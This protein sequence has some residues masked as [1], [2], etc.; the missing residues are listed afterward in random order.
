M[1]DISERTLADVIGIPHFVAAMQRGMARFADYRALMPN[2]ARAYTRTLL[3]KRDDYEL[4]AMLWAPASRSPIH[5]HG[6]SRCWVVVLEGAID[7]DN[8]ERL[9]DDERTPNL[10][11]TSNERVARGSIDHRLNDRELHRVQNRTDAP[12]FSLQ[13][14]ASPLGEYT[15]ADDLTGLWRRMPSHYDAIFDL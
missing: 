1:T 9:D 11:P 5:D 8:Y 14:Y 13:L 3:E 4:V 6:D 12:A 15:I 10:R 2:V 7:V